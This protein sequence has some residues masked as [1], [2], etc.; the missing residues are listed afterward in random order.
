MLAELWVVWCWLWCSGELGRA[1][2]N[3]WRWRW[4]SQRLRR[5][6]AEQMEQ[7]H[8][9]GE[10]GVHLRPDSECLGQMEAGAWHPHIEHALT[11]VGSGESEFFRF[12]L[13]Q[14]D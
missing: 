8:S 1:Q 5:A 13:H 3:K 10:R 2:R 12:E 9:R 11:P 14:G 4:L 6:R 7:G